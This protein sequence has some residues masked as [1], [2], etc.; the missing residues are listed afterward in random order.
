MK[1]KRVKY[2][3]HR[4]D[5]R[6]RTAVVKSEWKDRVLV[7]FEPVLGEEDGDVVRD[8]DSLC[9]GWHDFAADQFEEV[10]DD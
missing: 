3:G 7:Q 10:S 9:F 1:L 2:V 5:L 6:G 8:Y 4:E